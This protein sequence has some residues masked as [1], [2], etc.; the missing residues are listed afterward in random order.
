MLETICPSC[1]HRY[2]LGHDHTCPK[3]RGRPKTITDMRTYKA[4]KAKQY[5]ALAKA[6]TTD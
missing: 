3:K 6:K 4:N 1:Q 5:R 2:I